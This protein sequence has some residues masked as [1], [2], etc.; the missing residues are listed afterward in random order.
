MA[1]D[2]IFTASVASEEMLRV[3]ADALSM[4]APEQFLALWETEGCPRKAGSLVADCFVSEAAHI[5]VFAAM[6]AKRTPD[7]DLWLAACAEQFDRAV[8]AASIAF[9]GCEIRAVAAANAAFG[10]AKITKK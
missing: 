1:E 9:D 6:C 4:M 7:R 2:V 10:D 3:L 5:A 8:A